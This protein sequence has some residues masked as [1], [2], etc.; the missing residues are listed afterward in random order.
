MFRLCVLKWGTKGVGLWPLGA[1][2]LRRFIVRRW[3]RGFGTETPGH[4]PTHIPEP[5]HS[6]AHRCMSPRSFH[7]F[8]GNNSL[9]PLHPPSSSLCQRKS[10]FQTSLYVA[11]CKPE[12]NFSSNA[13]NEEEKCWQ[14][15]NALSG[16]FTRVASQL[17]WTLHHCTDWILAAVKGQHCNRV[18]QW[19]GNGG[20]LWDRGW[21][22]GGGR[23]DR[24]ERT[25]RN[26]AWITPVG[27]F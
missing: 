7:C 22:L 17:G 5:C 24:K 18:K 16:M 12:Q 11:W 21:M 15:V 26:S 3:E 27:W 9:T 4:W 2:T 25:R 8:S 6:C 23:D 1:P 14:N 13:L 10:S 20:K 19:N